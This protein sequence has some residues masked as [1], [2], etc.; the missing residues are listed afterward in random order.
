MMVSHHHLLDVFT[1]PKDGQVED[2]DGHEAN[3]VRPIAADEAL[4]LRVVSDLGGDSGQVQRGQGGGVHPLQGSNNVPRHRVQGL[5][6]V[7]ENNMAF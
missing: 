1:H 2:D 5:E 6:C 3:V 4:A 7:S